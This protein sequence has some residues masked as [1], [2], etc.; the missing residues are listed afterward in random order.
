MSSKITIILGITCLSFLVFL[1]IQQPDKNSL[2]IDSKIL[3]EQNKDLKLYQLLIGKT[4]SFNMFNTE[5]GIHKGQKNKQVLVF[6]FDDLT[7]QSCINEQLPKIEN[8][9]SSLKEQQVYIFYEGNDIKKIKMLKKVFRLKTK[10]VNLK[11]GFIEENFNGIKL[12]LLL[13]ID[14]NNSIVKI[15]NPT[16]LN[17]REVN[18]FYEYAIKLIQKA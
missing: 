14:D 2:P 11:K 10:I 4:L 8:I 9:N 12:P 1:Y 13:I 15:I 5:D 18:I 17:E 16:Y 7:C 3:I 6:I